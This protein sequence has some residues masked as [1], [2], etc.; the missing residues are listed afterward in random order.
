VKQPSFA[1]RRR[2][3]TQSEIDRILSEYARDGGTQ[4]E[5]A[6]C[7]GV[8]AATIRNWLQRTQSRDAPKS[9]SWVELV[10]APPPPSGNYRIELPNGRV[11][12]L[13]AQWQAGQVR[14]LIAAISGV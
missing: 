1:P 12:V 6:R 14:A 13:P 4:R 5:L 11:V 2:R 8:C 7:H 3:H 10:A 9:A